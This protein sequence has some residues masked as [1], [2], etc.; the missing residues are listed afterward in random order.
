MNH[1]DT[2]NDPPAPGDPDWET[3][4]DEQLAAGDF[5]P[6]LGKAMAADA[7]RVSSGELSE[8]AFYRRYHDAVV[9]EFGV[10]RRPSKDAEDA[11]DAAPEPRVPD[12]DRG[13]GGSETS[14]RS[15][16]KLFAGTAA[17]TV[18]L[19]G[20][21]GEGQLDSVIVGKSEDVVAETGAQN[22][23]SSGKQMGMVIDLERCQGALDCMQA[24]KQEN[25]TAVGVHWNYVFR[26]AAN[27]EGPADQYM[28]RPCQHCT[29]P[30]C[31]FVCPTEARHKRDSDGIVLTDYDGEN[32]AKAD[33][34]LE[35]LDFDGT[36]R[37]EQGD[38]IDTFSAIGGTFDIVLID[39][40]KRQYTNA[41]SLASERLEPGGVIVADNMMAGPVT[42]ESVSGALRGKEPVDAATAGIAQYIDSI[43]NAPDFET[44][45]LPLGEGIAVSHRHY[46]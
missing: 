41:F 1:Q 45:F 28:P 39:L 30:T 14:R 29:R 21:L 5:D 36:I 27:G 26:F 42:P 15:A 24:C 18:G 32:L 46:E 10:D 12:T 4:A 13:T 16:M 34:F 20:C 38:A 7:M 40:E 44:A 19:P 17:A 35:Q 33:R 11:G 37:Y 6:A 3:W 43:R 8:A 22:P 25:N 23:D 31:T 9:E 2:N